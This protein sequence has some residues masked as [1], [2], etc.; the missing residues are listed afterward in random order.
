M[1][2]L[3]ILAFSVWLTWISYRDTKERTSV[4]WSV[5]IVV[6][7]L[8]LHGTRPLES[9]FGLEGQTSRDEGS[10]LEATVNTVLIAAGLSVLIRRGIQ[11]GTVI[12]GNVWLAVFYL[13]WILSITWSDYPLITF[14]RLIK[15]FGYLI[16]ALV[17]LTDKVPTQ[18]IR[19]AVVRFSYICIPL[20]VIWIRY[21]PS[22]GREFVGYSKSTLMYVGVST[23]KNV[24]GNL[25]LASTL[26]VLW[27]LLEQWKEGKGKAIKRPLWKS[28]AMVLAMCWYLLLL[29]DSQT[30][31]VCAFLGSVLLI[32]LFKVPSWTYNPG[33]IE[34]VGIAGG[35]I[36]GLVNMFVDVK[37]V[38]LESVN[39]DPTLT[40]RTDIWPFLIEF[41]DNPLLGQGFNSFWAGER[42]VELQTV[43][44]GIIQAHNGYI[45]T[46]LNGGI[47]G[48]GLL[49]LLILGT[50]LRIRRHL[51]I[52]IPDSHIRLVI[53]IIAVIYNFSEASFNKIGPL[54]LVTVWAMMQYRSQL[55]PRRHWT[56]A[57]R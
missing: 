21:F 6:V 16:M 26:F 31:L 4:S 53:L 40:T 39:R 37:E 19:A 11:W 13:F 10:P 28:R 20:S 36:L 45:E 14:K 25:V 12:T 41:Q 54:W 49:G 7:W 17:V 44:F 3:I 35:T 15:D 52:G 34:L 1:G 29:I 47:I 22:L 56:G 18:S 9:W 57:S 27:E 43:T 23:H 38:F 42:L 55:S 50:Y 48:M 46:Y 8:F 5:W 33:R 30:S 2:Q 32:T 24:L 51:I